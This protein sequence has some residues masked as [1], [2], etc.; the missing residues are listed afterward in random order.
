MIFRFASILLPAELLLVG[1][2]LPPDALLGAF[3]LLVEL[4]RTQ[5]VAIALAVVL[6]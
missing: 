2:V 1:V 5:F 4:P 6:N 3:V